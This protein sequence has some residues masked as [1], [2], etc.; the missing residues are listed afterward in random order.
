MIYSYKRKNHC[1]SNTRKARHVVR[2]VLGKSLPE[3]AE[4]HHI[5][6]NPAN[7]SNDNLVVCENHSYHKLL[8]SRIQ[9]LLDCGN[10]KL[11]NCWLCKR[12]DTPENLKLSGRGFY[13][14]QCLYDYLAKRP[15]SSKCYL[16]N[17][18]DDTSNLVAVKGRPGQSYHKTCN[19]M[20]TRY[21]RMG[22]SHLYK[23]LAL[24]G[25]FSSKEDNN[26]CKD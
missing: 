6:G 23:E 8:H 13:H 16:C 19:K 5:D 24:S 26:V 1:G 7:N 25:L 14:K 22:L 20:K 2:E 21:R 9:S 10:A 4:I 15:S 18:I 12:Y 3:G 17:K 11:K